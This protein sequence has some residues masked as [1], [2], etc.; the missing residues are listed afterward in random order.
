MGNEK[1]RVRAFTLIEL[2][3]VIGVIAILAGILISAL[4]A[5]QGRSTRTRVRAELKAL[6]TVIESYKAKHNFY[7][8]DNP[9]DYSQPPLFYELTG[10]TNL[11]VGGVHQYHSKFAS[12]DP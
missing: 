10:T 8:P 2:L 9:K 3:V 4:P 1:L 7:P 12:A 5:A 6:E 11:A